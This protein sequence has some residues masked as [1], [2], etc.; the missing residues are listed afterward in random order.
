MAAPA[1]TFLAPGPATGSEQAAP[2]TPFYRGANERRVPTCCSHRP[3]NVCVCDEDLTLVARAS[4]E[5]GVLRMIL[6]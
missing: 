1:R 6:Q 3:P 4:R 2:G 5:P